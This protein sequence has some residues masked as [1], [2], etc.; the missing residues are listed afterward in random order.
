[1]IWRLRPLTKPQVINYFPQYK[2]DPHLEEY[3]DYCR[4]RL[5]LHHPFIDWDDLL[6]VDDQVYAMYVDAF[7]ACIQQHVHPK[8]FYTDLEES[9]E[10]G[11]DSDTN[12]DNSSDEGE[13]NNYLLADF[14]IF[15]HW[16]PQDDFPRMDISEGLSYRDMD[17]NF[18]WLIFFS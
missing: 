6:S 8:D 2:S 17:R 12:L 11:S 7:R 5:I 14:E 10:L 9:G 13:D 16:R 15:A 4:V 1:M 3:S 18:D